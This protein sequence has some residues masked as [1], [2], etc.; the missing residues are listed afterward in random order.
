MNMWKILLK[1]VPVATVLAMST[2]AYAHHS[3]AMFDDKKIVV[4]DGP[5]KK[6]D[7]ASPH[8]WIWIVSKDGKTWGFETEG[9]AALTRWGFRK[10]LIKVGDRI[11]VTGH[12][13]RDGT[14]AGSMMTLQ[15]GDGMIYAVG[16]PPHVATAADAAHPSEPK[17]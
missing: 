8:S 13:M 5:L 2:A 7:L 15:T 6:L 9:P 16:Q 3:F 4:I 14:N 12:P 11:S 1:A 17:F 10:S